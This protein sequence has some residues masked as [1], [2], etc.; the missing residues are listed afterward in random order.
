MREREVEGIRAYVPPAESPPYDPEAGPEGYIEQIRQLNLKG[1]VNYA[2]PAMKNEKRHIRGLADE[3]V[4]QNRSALGT[5]TWNVARL[6]GDDLGEFFFLNLR[7]IALPPRVLGLAAFE[8]QKYK[9]VRQH[10]PQARINDAKIRNQIRSQDISR[11]QIEAAKQAVLA[12]PHTTPFPDFFQMTSEQQKAIVAVLGA[13]WVE[14]CKIVSRHDPRALGTQSLRLQGPLS[15]RSVATLRQAIEQNPS[16]GAA[17]ICRLFLRRPREFEAD[18]E[19]A[20][21]NAQ[22]KEQLRLSEQRAQSARQQKAKLQ[23]QAE[24][25]ET[26]TRRKETDDTVEKSAPDIALTGLVTITKLYRSD[27]GLLMED[28]EIINKGTQRFA[29]AHFSFEYLVDLCTILPAGATYSL[30]E[31]RSKL[32]EVW[33]PGDIS[34]K[35][36]NIAQDMPSGIFTITE[37]AISIG[38]LVLLGRKTTAEDMLNERKRRHQR[39]RAAIDKDRVSILSQDH[40]RITVNHPRTGEQLYYMSL[41]R[42]KALLAA[43]IITVLESKNNTNDKFIDAAKV[44][45]SVW[46]QMPTAERELFTSRKDGIV[47]GPSP[48]KKPVLEVM[49]NLT[50]ILGITR[51]TSGERF[52][53]EAVAT[54]TIHEDSPEP[55]ELKGFRSVFPPG[56]DRE[57][58][59]Q[60]TLGPIPEQALNT[61]KLL[62]EHQV[63]STEPLSQDQAPAILDLITDADVKR[64]IRHHVKVM[65]LGRTSASVLEA[66]RDQV[67]RALGD[68]FESAW[69]NRMVAGN[70]ATGDSQVRLISGELPIIT[71]ASRFTTKKWH[72]GQSTG[73]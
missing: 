64:A 38:D 11:G 53:L 10:L 34:R 2:Y 52:N 62:L 73:Q 49:R 21:R 68:S 19:L 29:S 66:L 3:L 12:L 55:S 39:E 36:R 71:N 69:R 50:R 37:S 61:A 13:E 57:R 23:A 58:I 30:R 59:K 5:S 17:D 9:A 6:T 31:V 46:A 41:D 44:A 65:N 70:H 16:V 24:V 51:E 63:D 25:R 54:I 1:S 14:L 22:H 35:L 33:D 7:G 43:R 40:A 27:A 42:G 45:A 4:A 56:T 48:V 18:L 60:T 8:S 47:G 72:I 28:V 67:R 20:R 15:Y 32:A 26:E